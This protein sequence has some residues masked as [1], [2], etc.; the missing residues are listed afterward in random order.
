M[1]G[2]L[3]VLEFKNAFLS[4]FFRGFEFEKRAFGVT[5]IESESLC[6]IDLKTVDPDIYFFV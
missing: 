1:D 3:F 4:P 5:S 6:V 2:L